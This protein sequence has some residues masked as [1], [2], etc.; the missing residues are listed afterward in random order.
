MRNCRVAQPSFI[1][2]MMHSLRRKLEALRDMTQL[3]SE[4]VVASMPSG[5]ST[6]LT[7]TNA[8]S[9]RCTALLGVYVAVPV[10]LHEQALFGIKMQRV[11][12][13]GVRAAMSRRHDVRR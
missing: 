8:T 11:H 3:P 12:T 4:R 5:A 10:L 2:R 13:L 7:R 9:T 6:T 1:A